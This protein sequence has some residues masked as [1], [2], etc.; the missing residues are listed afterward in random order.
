MASDNPFGIFKLLSVVFSVLRFTTSDNP[1][2][3][4]K[5][6]AIALSVLRFTASDNPFGIFKLLAIVLS[7]HTTDKSLKIPKGLSEAINRRT[8]NTMTKRY[9]RGHQM[10]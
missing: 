6:L 3:I 9:Q 1:F 8:D 4:F 10:P 2:G 7:V 5:L